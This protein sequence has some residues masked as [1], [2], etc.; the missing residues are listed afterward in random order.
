MPNISTLISRGNS[1]IL[2]EIKIL[3]P[4]IVT[5]LSKQTGP[6]KGR[7]QIVC[8]VYKAEVLNP[9]SNSNNRNNKKSVCEFNARPF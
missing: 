4:Q 9:S 8:L 5:V 1:K 6:L 7:Y 2:R 3:N